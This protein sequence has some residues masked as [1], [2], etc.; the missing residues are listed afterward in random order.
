[1]KKAV[2]AVAPDKYRD[3]ELTEPVA[4]LTKAGIA[5]D[6]AST[7]PGT[8]KGMFGGKTTASLSFEEVDPKNYDG[9]IIIGGAGSQTYLWEDEVLVE[10]ARF[11]HE[12]DKVV[13]AI[14]L[15]PAVL[16]RSGILKGKKA[17]SYNSP[18]A[19]FEMKKGGAVLV[20]QPV[21]TDH[22]IIT[23]NGPAAAKDF[24]AAVVKELS[25][26]FW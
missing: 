23:A 24:A 14:C 3:E 17:T 2:I 9:L 21:V 20:N 7:R 13:A 16:A 5:F 26:E 15:A 11:F 6:I 12:S 22:R 4:A 10:L 19:F 18:A 25:D 1:M 8:C